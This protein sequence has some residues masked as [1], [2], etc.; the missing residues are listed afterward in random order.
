M[1]LLQSYFVR[2]IIKG[3]CESCGFDPTTS[4]LISSTASAV[5]AATTCDPHGHAVGEIAHHAENLTNLH[6]HVGNVSDLHQHFTDHAE[7]VGS[8]AG[9]AYN[10]NSD[11]I[12]LHHP[13]DN[14][15]FCVSGQNAA[16]V[17]DI[18][19]YAD[20]SKNHTIHEAVVTHVDRTK[21]SYDIQNFNHYGKDGD[22]ASISET[23]VNQRF[24]GLSDSRTSN[25]SK[26]EKDAITSFIKTLG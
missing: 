5:V 21:G 7:R 2:N 9:H 26:V 12:N 1:S 17:S 25:F 3:V 22:T 8:E 11:A 19:S 23:L 24:N 4:Y 14:S 13:N 10:A 16:K 15:S 20:S 6:D 18:I